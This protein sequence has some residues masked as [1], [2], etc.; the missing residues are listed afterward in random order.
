MFPLVGLGGVFEKRVGPLGEVSDGTFVAGFFQKRGQPIQG[1]IGVLT[2]EGGASE[3]FAGFHRLRVNLHSLF[4]KLDGACGVTGLFAGISE[5]V[6]GLG[7]DSQGEASFQCRKGIARAAGVEES[8]S[9]RQKEFVGGHL[10]IVGV[11][12]EF[13]HSLPSLNRLPEVAAVVFQRSE[14][15]APAGFIAGDLRKLFRV[16]D[17]FIEVAELSVGGDEFVEN[18]GVR[19]IQGVEMLEQGNRIAP[20]LLMEEC[21]RPGA[22]PRGSDDTNP[23]EQP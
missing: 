19:R 7:G 12:T 10:Q 16:V 2:L 8:L 23:L 22:F 20:A 18:V 5:V 3:S 11:G 9:E 13:Q 14:H 4:P 17:G 1:L 15:Q 6:L 21:K